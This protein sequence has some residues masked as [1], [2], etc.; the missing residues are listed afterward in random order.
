MSRLRNLDL[1]YYEEIKRN[2][3]EMLLIKRKGQHVGNM[4]AKVL[5]VR[6]YGRNS[7]I[8]TEYYDIARIQ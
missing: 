6:L 7:G 3:I 2:Q 5:G 1:R 8:L 4:P